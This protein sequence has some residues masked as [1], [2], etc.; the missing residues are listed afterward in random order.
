M[1]SPEPF[2]HSP[3]KL[4]LA[5]ALTILETCHS[6]SNF[7][8]SECVCLWTPASPFRVSR[9]CTYDC[10]VS[11]AAIH[12]RFQAAN[13]GSTCARMRG[14]IK[15]KLPQGLQADWESLPVKCSNPQRSH[16][17]SKDFH[18][19]KLSWSYFLFIT[20]TAVLPPVTLLFSL[21]GID[22]PDQHFTYAANLCWVRCMSKCVNVYIVTPSTIWQKGYTMMI[23]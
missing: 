23:F 18:G 8:N 11:S 3:I 2:R 13:K 20:L 5:V 15:Q 22:N 6:H 16:V 1:A 4:Y 12:A 19:K 17:S 10:S 7:F 14:R 21:H 9:L